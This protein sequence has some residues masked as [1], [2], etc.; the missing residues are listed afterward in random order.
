MGNSGWN[1]R[2]EPV[3]QGNNDHR[4]S[5]L[6]Q[7]MFASLI[8]IGLPLFGAVLGIMPGILLGF[9]GWHRIG[10]VVIAVIFFVGHGFHPALAH[11]RGQALHWG[12]SATFTSGLGISIWVFGNMTAN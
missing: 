4:P 10:A 3:Q 8:I 2:S 7:V 6:W 1:S 5:F 12:G 9:A 11:L